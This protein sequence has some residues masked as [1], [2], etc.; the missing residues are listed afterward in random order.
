MSA[1]G[2]PAAGVPRLRPAGARARVHGDGI[3][4]VEAFSRGAAIDRGW[5][6][7]GALRVL[8]HQD[9]APGAA[10]D[11]GRVANVERLLLVLD[12]ALEADCGGLGRHRAA[13]GQA[14]WIGAG[15]GVESRLANASPDRALR[16]V[17]IWLQPDRVN[18]EPAVEAG[19]MGGGTDGWHLVAGAPP[20]GPP[21]LPLRAGAGLMMAG[22]AAGASLGI[23]GGGRRY[24]LE[25]LDG[26]VVVDVDMAGAGRDRPGS[27]I[28]MSAGDGLG[29]PGG[30]GQVPASIAAEGAGPARLLLLALPD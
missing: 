23:P 28:R 18:A 9:W 14:L 16:L 24:W 30:T 20:A 3:V 17:E 15:H 6:G 22:L 10:R 27:G 11:D 25:L 19:S 12:G 8:S 7:W 13:A 1:A 29:W 4:A 26:E 2:D 5:M 21:P